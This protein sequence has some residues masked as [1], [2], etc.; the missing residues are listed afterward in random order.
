MEA[1]A[2]KEKVTNA[3]SK[4]ITWEERANKA[5]GTVPMLQEYAHLSNDRIT[6]LV[7]T[8]YVV[9]AVFLAACA[10]KYSF[11]GKYHKYTTADPGRDLAVQSSTRAA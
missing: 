6:E 8:N 10:N 4:L 11:A 2:A 9:F 3:N 1:T 7:Q 5:E